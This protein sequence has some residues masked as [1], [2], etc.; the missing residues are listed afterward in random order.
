MTSHNLDVPIRMVFQS[1]NHTKIPMAR[2]AFRAP[3]ASVL[4]L[5]VVTA[6]YSAATPAWAQEGLFDRIFGGSERLGGGERSAPSPGR[7]ARERFN[8]PV[9]T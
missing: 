7:S 6:A 8:R 4:A 2:L 3:A 9:P 5:A 1:L